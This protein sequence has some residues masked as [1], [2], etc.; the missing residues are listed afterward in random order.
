MK[1]NMF[2][3]DTM[4]AL[5]RELVTRLGPDDGIILVVL[6]RGAAA[7]G[8]LIRPGNED[9]ERLMTKIEEA[10]VGTIGGE[11]QSFE[12]DIVTTVRSGKPD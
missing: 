10:I 6:N 5:L 7:H 12:R 1:I 11:R 9:G 4:S 8:G 3:R 2:D